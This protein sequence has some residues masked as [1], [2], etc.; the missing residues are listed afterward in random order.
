MV[1]CVLALSLIT[2]MVLGSVCTNADI[3]VT[4]KIYADFTAQELNPD[5]LVGNPNRGQYGPRH[6]LPALAIYS[7]TGDKKYGEAIKSSL[8]FYDQWLQQEIENQGAHF[9]WEGPYLCGF[10]I[11]KLRE[12]GLLTEDDEKWVRDMFIRLAE[13]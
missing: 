4:S 7:F 8:K 1:S 13:A 11:Q 12:G 5:G 9:S 2:P 3:A 6:A 10:H